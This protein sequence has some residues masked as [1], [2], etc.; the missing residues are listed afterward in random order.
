VGGPVHVDHDLVEG[1]II[2]ADDTG[3]GEM[4]VFHTPGHS[5]GSISL[6]L[7]SE[8]ALFSGDA[9]P[10]AGDLPVYDNAVLSVKSV[11]RL[12]G[13]AGIRVLLSSWDD[14]RRGMR[15][16]RKWIKLLSTSV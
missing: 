4:L 7:Q 10:V 5:Y 6:H 8:R 1:D 2:E 15:H 13:F 9:I 16:T 12:R 3:A 11:K 14:P